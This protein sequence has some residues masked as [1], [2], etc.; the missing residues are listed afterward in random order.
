MLKS[1]SR[2]VY[3]Y[4]SVGFVFMFGLFRIKEINKKNICIA[5]SD[6]LFESNLWQVNSY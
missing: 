2:Y 6:R 4:S 1:R 5:H 3:R